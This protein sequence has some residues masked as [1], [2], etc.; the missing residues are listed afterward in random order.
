MNANCKKKKKKDNYYAILKHKINDKMKDN[1]WF[2]SKDNKMVF[3]SVM[4]KKVQ[5]PTGKK[6]CLG[7]SL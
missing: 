5:T 6:K 2:E 7:G 3:F 1:Q 4:M